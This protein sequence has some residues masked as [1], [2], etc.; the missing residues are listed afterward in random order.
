MRIYNK[1]FLTMF[2]VLCMAAFM[3][4]GCKSKKSSDADGVSGIWQ[5][6]KA[7]GDEDLTF[8][9]RDDGSGHYAAD[10]G[11]EYDIVYITK[12]NEMTMYYSEGKNVVDDFKWKRDGKN[13]TLTGS[14]GTAWNFR[15]AGE[16][17]ETPD[18]ALLPEDMKA[19][20]ADQA[21]PSDSTDTSAAGKI[22]KPKVSWKE[23]SDARG[24]GTEDASEDDTDGSGM[25]SDIND[26][27][28]NYCIDL[29]GDWKGQARF[30]NVEGSN[31]PI[32]GKHGFAVMRISMLPENS[33][34]C[35]ITFSIHPEPIMYLNAH[36]EE[37]GTLVAEGTMSVNGREDEMEDLRLDYDDDGYYSGTTRISDEYGDFDVSFYF[38]RW[39]EDWFNAGEVN[40]SDYD[41]TVFNGTIQDVVDGATFTGDSSWV[42]PLAEDM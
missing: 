33:G 20:E 27:I 37:D 12:N 23:A 39:D 11:D 10:G 29:D 18:G 13:L 6:D 14:D 36:F 1:R 17:D 7:S 9:F 16:A 34:L 22:S 3:L 28:M 31:A 24:G 42:P 30:S 32:E 5:Y 4:A 41:L 21:D 26:D 19:A 40:F 25:E 8:T 38:V 15:Y 2:L 35:Y